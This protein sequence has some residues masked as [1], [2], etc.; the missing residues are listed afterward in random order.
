[1]CIYFTGCLMK[2]IKLNV[3]ETNIMTSSPIT[4]WQIDGENWEQWQTLC[5]WAP[6]SLQMVIA[7][8]K[9]RHL[10]LGRK[11]MTNLDSILKI[12]DITLLMKVW[13]H[14]A[15][16]FPLAMYKCEYWTI[17]KAE[18]WT[19]IAFKQWCWKRLLRVPCTARRSNH[20]KDWCWSWSANTLATWCEELT[21]WKRPW[22]WERP[23]ARE[24]DDRGWDGWVVSPTQKTWIWV[25]S[26][27]IVKDREA[28]NA[29]VNGFTKSWI[30]LSNWTTSTEWRKGKMRWKYPCYFHVLW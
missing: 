29:A 8:M 5:S 2:R 3:W 11:Y 14:K 16:V 22:G 13:M 9:L 21:H 7:V 17:K 1:M 6:E 27:K 18:R 10:L 30:R 24:G 4:L 23:R 12:R 19:I 25:N 26:Q 20:W 28:W 15:M